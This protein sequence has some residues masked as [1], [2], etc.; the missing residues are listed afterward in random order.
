MEIL[1]EQDH[2][3]QI[4]RLV[5][6]DA[7]PDAQRLILLTSDLLTAGFLQQNAL[8][9]IDTYASPQKQIRMLDL[10]LRF[11]T[12]AQSIVKRG[13]V[14]QTLQQLPVLHELLTMKNR[15]SNDDL[16]RFDQLSLE[17]DQQL[18]ALEEKYL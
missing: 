10:I 17:L 7:L 9:E 11:H 8:D 14:I 4:V 18:A 2:L 16:S 1:T 3:N 13:A 5:G 15:I 12:K 6:P